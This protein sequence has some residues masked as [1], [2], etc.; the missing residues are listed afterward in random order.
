MLH[1]GVVSSTRHDI[2]VQPRNFNI[3]R[4][5]FLASEDYKDRN[6]ADA[7]GLAAGQDQQEAG[8]VSP[9]TERLESNEGY[10]IQSGE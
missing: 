10:N 7:A 4:Q 1:S 9:R 2:R 6:V 5:Q 3:M 8:I